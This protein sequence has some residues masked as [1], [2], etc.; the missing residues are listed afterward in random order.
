MQVGMDRLDF[1]LIGDGVRLADWEPTQTV[2]GLEFQNVCSDEQILG[3][4]QRAPGVRLADYN[5][6]PESRCG[7]PP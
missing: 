5:L 1:H 4:R 6:P 2:G 7:M 3:H